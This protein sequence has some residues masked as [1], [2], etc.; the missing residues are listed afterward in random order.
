MKKSIPHQLH[1]Q[2]CFACLLER[3]SSSSAT[4]IND[5]KRLM[6]KVKT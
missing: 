5:V 6:S 2:D 4:S 1:P 3:R